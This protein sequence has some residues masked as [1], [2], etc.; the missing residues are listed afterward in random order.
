MTCVR[1]KNIS[2]KY[3]RFTTLGSKDIGI[4]KILWSCCVLEAN[5]LKGSS[6]MI[7][8]SDIQRSMLYVSIIIIKLYTIHMIAIPGQTAE[9][10]SLKIKNKLSFLFHA[11]RQ[12]FKLV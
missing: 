3:Q 12:A 2:L 11:E 7:G 10:N 9:P 4:R 8:H 1:S 5:R 6:V